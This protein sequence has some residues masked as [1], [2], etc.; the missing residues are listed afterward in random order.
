MTTSSWGE[1]YRE[2]GGTPVINAMGHVT[3]LGGSSLSP[4]VLEAVE[5][6]NKVYIPLAELEEKA[7]QAIANML[8]VE[9][10]YVTSG[11]FSALVL[12]CAACM[13]G[14][15]PRKIEQLPDTTGM[16]N[17]FVIQ[18]RQRYWYDR[19]ITTAGGKI[20][21][22]G[23]DRG[24]T[25]RQLEA[26]IGPRTAALYAFAQGSQEGIVPI[27][28]IVRVARAHDLPVVIDAAGEVYPTDKL[29]MYAKMGADLV[30]YGAKYIGAP[31][32]TG[33]LI[34][35]R[36]MIN[37]AAK[38]SFISYESNQVRSLGRGMKIDRQ[39]IIA[40][41]AALRE[42]LTTD[43]E[44][45][46]ARFDARINVITRALRGVKG[47]TLTPTREHVLD[48]GVKVEWDESVVKKTSAQVLEAL[49][50]GEPSIWA[51]YLDWTRRDAPGIRV[52]VICL[53]EGEDAIVARRVA[54]VLKG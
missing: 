3:L 40:V 6:A 46:L 36:D 32:S 51:G 22:A 2:L 9:G 52:S 16:K 26:A 42:W 53:N 10:A 11:A 31:H 41:V 48:W 34:G 12:A 35:S 44:E 7:G 21:E 13:A 30:A 8:G 18:K 33:M 43:H 15:D 25:E 17:E 23:D 1:I 5:Q 14:D 29:S 49:K 20:I 50:Q 39:E 54:A 45:R 28:A 19:S 47:V 4:R 27:E 37:K 38:Q 24:T